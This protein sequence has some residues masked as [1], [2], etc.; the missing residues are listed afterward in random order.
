[1]GKE[2]IEKLFH[3]RSEKIDMIGQI[4]YFPVLGRPLIMWLGVVT[5][6]CL[7]FTATIAFLNKRRIRKIPMK[8]HP[9]M[10]KIT[11]VI[12][13]IHGLLGLLLYI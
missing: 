11:L 8:Y 13:L 10:A 4:A 2:K 7:F 1:M 6:L 9:L 5:L 3:R 12:A